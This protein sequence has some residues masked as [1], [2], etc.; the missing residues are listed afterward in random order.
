MVTVRCAGCGRDFEAA[1]VSRRTCSTACRKRAQRQR[2]GAEG[3]HRAAAATDAEAQRKRAGATKRKRNQ[4]KREAELLAATRP[5]ASSPVPQR[6]DLAGWCSELVI[7]QG[8]GVGERIRMLDWELDF[9][10]DV[11][12]LPR[13]ELG[14]S[15]PSGAGKTTL[16]AA[17]CGAAVA[18]PL[19]QPR[20]DVIG[21]AASFQ[22]ALILADHVRAFLAPIIERDPERWRVLRS[23]QRALIEDVST[24]ARFQAREASA[25]TL[26][27]S[28]PSLIVA[29]EPAQWQWS[30]RDAIYSAIRSRLGKIPGARLVAI[31][32]RP[33]GEEHW[34]AKLLSRNPR[35]VHAA[36]GDDDPFAEATWHKANPSLAHFAELLETYRREA[37]EAQQDGSL[38][39]PFRALRLNLGT[40]DA[41]QNWLLEPSTWE[42]L[43]ECD[44]LPEAPRRYVLGLDLGGSAAMSAAAAYWWKTGRLE[45]VGHF[46]A[47]PDLSERAR[48]DGAG[49]LYERMRAEGE[50]VV[51]PGRVVEAA[52]VLRDAI[53]RWGTP[54]AV[55]ADRYREAE[56]R[57]GLANTHGRCYVEVR[58]M[59]YVEGADDVRTFQRAVL[60]GDVHAKRS[61]LLR[62]AI[63]EARVVGDTSGANF[64][65][66]KSSEGGRRARLRDDAAA[67]SILAVA[68]GCREA[69]R[70]TNR[71]P[72][73]VYIA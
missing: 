61:L 1:R 16:V 35:H 34:F 57:Q 39:A 71:R 49:D 42:R 66:A 62:S 19:A 23:E 59:G 5:A 41:E 40:H 45:A 30:Q 50:L 52:A 46:A 33:V 25:R 3:Q 73:R 36:G 63:G 48:R 11:E 32:T 24:G 37:A 53:E 68:S 10:A 28:A 26:H 38:L 47:V 43:V 55:V 17:V 58:G 12:R 56:L 69:I 15:V 21:V 13:G 20:G 18:G 2:R 22:Q 67:A 8:Q 65:L 54:V 70:E 31:G 44:I 60:A 29:D 4:R 51:H 64:K 72:L 14:L 7:T 9:L 27:G 6:E